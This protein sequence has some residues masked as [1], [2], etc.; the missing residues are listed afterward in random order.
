MPNLIHS[1][2][3]TSMSLLYK[4]FTKKYPN[5]QFFSLHDC[6]GTTSD[7]VYILK[8]LLVSVYT[9]LYS[10]DHYLIKFDHYLI[11]FDHD[12]LETCFFFLQ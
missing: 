3:A 10:N 5:P 1:L 8:T 6:F 12:L 7:K 11:K 4:I 9:Y 2:D